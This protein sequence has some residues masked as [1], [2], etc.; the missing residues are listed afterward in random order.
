MSN[1]PQ[2]MSITSQFKHAKLNA[3][4]LEK[5]AHLRTRKDRYELG[6]SLRDNCPRE[7][8][9]EYTVDW[10]QRKD[11][12]EL[13]VESSAGR[14][15]SLLPIRYG[16]MATSPF[17]FFRGAAITMAADLVQM[18]DTSYAVQSCGDSHLCNFGAFA[19]P[20]RNVIFDIN[21]FDETFPATWEWDL[22]RLASSFIIASKHNGHSKSDRREAAKRTVEAYR[23]RMLELAEMET[24][25]AWY[26]FL[27]FERLID[28]SADRKYK[29]KRRKDLSKARNRGSN[30]EFVKLAHLV[31]GEPRIK[32]QP[33]LIYHDPDYETD[34][35]KNAVALAVTHYRDSLPV[36]RRALFDRYELADTAIKV[37]GVGSVGTMCVIALFFAAENDPL[38]LQVKE[39]RPSVLEAYSGFRPFQTHGERVVFGQRLLQAASDIFLGHFVGL[40]KNR[41]FYVRQLRDIKVK[42]PVEEFSP[43]EMLVYAQ[44]CGWALAR[45]HARS[46]D[47][48]IIS[49]YIGKGSSFSNAVAQCAEKYETQNKND[50]N[51]LIDAI[52][53]GE[54]AA[55]EG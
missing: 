32:D 12:I 3:D 53:S 45:A 51:R 20:E 40:I 1:K 47:P 10:K 28:E 17:A 24:L 4:Y 55:S 49:A 35:F 52:K 38:F 43:R 23:D 30:S 14:I 37:V 25:T 8:H 26:D 50:Y 9:A 31:E 46:G 22:K 33:P 36:E 5:P 16:R 27:C 11:P 6:R 29:E 34:A 7:S 18:P 15:E 42:L 2:K 39:A 19:T 21:D 44:K 13:L 41:H 48:A 54:L